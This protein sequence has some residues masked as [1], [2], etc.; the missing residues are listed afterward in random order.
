M[1]GSGSGSYY[2][3]NSK[4]IVEDGLTLNLGKLVRDGLVIPG[5]HVSG[6]IVW[7]RVSSGE[8]TASIG[9]EADLSKPNIAFM[10]LHY[11]HNEKPMDYMVSLT[12]TR[13]HF[14]G[15]RWWFVCPAC[16]RRVAK[17]H[18]PPGGDIFASRAAYGLAYHSQRESPLFRQL[19]ITQEIR[20]RLGGGRCI[21]DPFPDKPKGMH[22]KTYWKLRGK[23]EWAGQRCNEEAI[24]RFGCF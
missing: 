5:Q 13:P 22:W 8:E 2:R 10:R 7:R 3:W 16:G 23:A 14:G 17:L 21:D 19:T 9:Y 1:G 24:R 18:S 11:R 12:T 6:S 20:E 15:L 4:T